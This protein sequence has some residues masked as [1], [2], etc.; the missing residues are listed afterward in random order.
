MVW[1]PKVTV[2][3]IEAVRR[4]YTGYLAHKG[5]NDIYGL[6]LRQMEWK[7]HKNIAKLL[8]IPINRGISWACERIDDYVHGKS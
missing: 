5:R 8:T 4:V 3:L 6:F 7:K 1:G 2:S